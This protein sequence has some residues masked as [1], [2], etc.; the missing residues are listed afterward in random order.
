M[1]DDFDG[2]GID[3][4]PLDGGSDDRAVVAV[5]RAEQIRRV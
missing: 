5:G 2:C 1:G 3:G 4:V